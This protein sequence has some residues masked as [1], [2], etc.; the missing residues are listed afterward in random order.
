METELTSAMLRAGEWKDAK[1]KNYNF[2]AAGV[3]GTGGH[4]HPLMMVREQ[5]K[6]IFLEMGF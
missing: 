4:L 6:E 5:F 3:E 2:N 1:F